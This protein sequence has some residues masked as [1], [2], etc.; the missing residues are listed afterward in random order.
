MDHPDWGEKLSR[1]EKLE[2][3]EGHAIWL[4]HKGDNFEGLMLRKGSYGKLTRKRDN[5][6]RK[7]DESKPNVSVYHVDFLDISENCHSFASKI[8]QSGKKNIDN[9]APRA[10]KSSKAKTLLAFLESESSGAKSAIENDDEKK[11]NDGR[12]SVSMGEMT[13]VSSGKKPRK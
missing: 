1:K 13:S 11:V 8:S 5:L 2:L 7:L 12:K 6:V 3:I 4:F 10:K 9:Q